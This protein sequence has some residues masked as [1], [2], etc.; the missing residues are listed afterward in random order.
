M[1]SLNQIYED[2]A[3]LFYTDT[4]SLII[5]IITEESYRDIADDDKKWFDTSNYEENNKR[6]L[7][8]GKNKEYMVF[9]K[10]N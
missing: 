3:K 8:I 10:M 1:I 2:K 6:P 4:D 7:A 5:H 9:S